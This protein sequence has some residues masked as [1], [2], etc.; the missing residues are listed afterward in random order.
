MLYNCKQRPGHLKIC[1]VYLVLICLILYLSFEE[2]SISMDFLLKLHLL[3]KSVQAISSKLIAELSR[4]SDDCA[5]T[6]VK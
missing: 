5:D 2:D 6:R 3:S 4:S 1:L